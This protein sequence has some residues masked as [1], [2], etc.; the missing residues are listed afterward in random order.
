M[1]VPVLGALALVQFALP[2]D[3]VPLARSAVARLALPPVPQPPPLVSVPPALA[4]RGLFAPGTQAGGKN[5]TTAPSADP[6]GGIR[7]AGTVRVGQTMRALVQWPD[8][9]ITYA[10]VGSRLGTW[11]LVA[12]TSTGA[13]LSG[14]SGSLNVT[15]GSRTQPLSP[16]SEDE[17]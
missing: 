9:R 17:Q 4:Q 7:I 6:L 16:V 2:Q 15:F 10:G 14:S 5:A 1:L 13:R 8:G 3:D 11:N 12:L